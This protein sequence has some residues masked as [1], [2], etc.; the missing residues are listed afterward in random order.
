M[1]KVKQSDCRTGWLIVNYAGRVLECEPVYRR[2]EAA[3]ER[4]ASLNQ[5]RLPYACPR[6]GQMSDT[7]GICQSC[8]GRDREPQ[9]ETVK[10]FE[11]APAQ[12]SG[13]MSL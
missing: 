12:I 13:Q 11:P 5:P 10:L 3:V 9:G 6:C 2:H 1:F 4:C 8:R 7:A